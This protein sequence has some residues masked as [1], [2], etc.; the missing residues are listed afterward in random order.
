[1]F[2]I[3]NGS[4]WNSKRCVLTGK[5][6]SALIF[7]FSVLTE[8]RLNTFRVMVSPVGTLTKICISAKSMFLVCQSAQL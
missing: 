1:M 7:F 6:S 8:F 5:P 2:I 3:S 4:F